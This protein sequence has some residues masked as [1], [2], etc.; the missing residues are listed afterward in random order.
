[1][2]TVYLTTPIYYVNERPHIGHCYTTVL[3][4]VAARFHRLFGRDVFF[5]TGTDEHAD[6]V[7]DTAAAHGMSTPQWADRN[8]EH[9]RAA[10][11]LL[12]VSND[13]F[14]RTSQDRHKL[15]VERYIADL[16]AAGH[17]YKGAYTGWWDASQEEYLTETTAK[18][19]GFKSPV[20]G[21]PL[22]QRT[23]DNYFFR[24]SAFQ[25]RLAAHIDANPEFIMPQARR[26]EVLGR[27]RQGLSDVPVSRSAGPPAAGAT[28]GVLMPGDPAHKVYVWIDALFNYL[29]VIDTEP[30]RRFWPPAVHVIAKDILWF[31][32]VVWPCMLMALGQPLPRTVYAHSYFVRDGRK[33][34][35][36]LGNFVDMALINAYCRDFSRDA[37]RW[38]LATQGPL[39][40]T[41]ADFAHDKFVEVYNAELAN[42]LGNCAARVGNMIE[43]FSDA[44]VPDPGPHAAG[45]DDLPAYAWPSA[46]AAL[47]RA[48]VAHA[49]SFEIDQALHR[50][51]ELVRLVDGYINATEPFKLAKRAAQGSPE[52]ARLDAILFHC[53]EALRIASLLMSPALP[54]ASNALWSAWGCAPPHATP[55]S[56][57]SLW[58]GPHGLRPG[59]PL[60]KGSPLFMR[61]D[62]A[63]PPP[64][65][66]QAPPSPDTTRA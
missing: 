63:A 26:N 25:D 3:T 34:S 43:K 28:W 42:G 6:K 47:V 4:D 22:A 57:L 54:D 40:S 64:T 65:P 9:F 5:L 16:Q 62:P 14:I 49:D 36:S 20:T 44:R 61:A 55:L 7:A 24:L 15:R 51:V 53:A 66:S 29:S 1:M 17:V 8:A 52:R 37:L 35:K 23:E 48:A 39:G 13:D 30:R 2:P 12:A 38:F 31:H 11:E 56:A 19:H 46:T 32:A 41:D 10:F 18:E 45:L 58:A 60:R 27:L 50:G 59:A 21:K 33:M